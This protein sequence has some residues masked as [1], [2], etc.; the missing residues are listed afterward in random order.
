MVLI[1]ETVRCAGTL[2]NVF[3][4]VANF[5]NT[6]EWDPGV[7]SS[8]KITTGEDFGVG[9]EYDVVTVFKDKKTPMKFKTT[10]YDAPNKIVLE[11]TGPTVTT[12]DTIVFKA[13]PEDP[14]HYTIVDYSAEI[15]LV[16]WKAIV[17]PLIKRPLRKVGQDAMAG[18]QQWCLVNAEKNHKG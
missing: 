9:T 4:Y 10:V 16:G 15:K 17:T 8:K 11:G 14:A 7:D 2:P 13:D 6:Q 5:V 12:V 3:K 18:L 1:R